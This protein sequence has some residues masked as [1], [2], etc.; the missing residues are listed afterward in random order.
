MKPLSARP[1]GRR[2][3]YSSKWDREARAFRREHP[4]CVGCQAIGGIEP[5]MLVDHIEPHRGDQAKF[6]N[7]AN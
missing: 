1:S 3:G 5:A 2:R 6:W 7:R 4:L